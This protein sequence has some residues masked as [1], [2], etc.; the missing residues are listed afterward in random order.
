MERFDRTLETEVK[1]RMDCVLS[2]IANRMQSFAGDILLSHSAIESSV[3]YTRT[4]AVC[5]FRAQ[6]FCVEV[7]HNLES[8][9]NSRLMNDIYE[10]I[11]NVRANDDGVIEVRLYETTKRTKEMCFKPTS[12]FSQT[13]EEEAIVYEV[14]LNGEERKVSRTEM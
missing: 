9:R 4:G 3:L 13:S 8:A 2:T 5:G 7:S 11:M 14:F 12:V 6:G 1:F 10:W